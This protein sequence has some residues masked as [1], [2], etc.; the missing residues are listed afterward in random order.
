MRAWALISPLHLFLLTPR[1]KL[2]F[3]S[4]S[5]FNLGNQGHGHPQKLPTTIPAPYKVGPESARARALP[6]P[7]LRFW[8]RPFAG[9]PGSNKKA[10]LFKAKEVSSGYTELPLPWLTPSAV[11]EGRTRQ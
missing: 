7:G 9:T 6:R 5:G 2:L 4:L 8:G 10:L 1:V 11:L 3:H